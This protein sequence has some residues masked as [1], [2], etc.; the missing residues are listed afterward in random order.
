MQPLTMKNSKP[1]RYF[2][3]ILFFVLLAV[4]SIT[5]VACISN[6]HPIDGEAPDVELTLDDTYDQVRNGARL[7]LTHEADSN[8]FN[9]FVENTTDEL[10]PLVRVEVHLSNGLELGPTSPVDLAPGESVAVRL[11]AKNFIFDTWTAHLKVGH[12]TVEQG[13]GGSDNELGEGG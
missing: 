5:A 3:K 9:G 10:L 4:T 1:S 6:N 7:V 12:D 13:P 11:L 2:S 8:S